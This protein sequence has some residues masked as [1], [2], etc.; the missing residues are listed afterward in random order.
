[1]VCGDCIRF[2]RE[3]SEAI[4][5]ASLRR[6]EFP[7]HVPPREAL[8]I[9]LK[10]ARAK[11]YQLMRVPMRP[12]LTGNNIGV[13]RS[14]FLRING[15][16]ERYVGWGLEDRD[17]QYRLERVGVRAWSILA[18]TR[19]IHLWHEPHPTFA[20]NGSG[21]PNLSYFSN[22]SRR[23]A[24]CAFGLVKSATVGSSEPAR[25]APPPFPQAI[26]T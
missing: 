4:D 13:W 8:R 15:F 7:W 2:G 6:G 26:A 12:R 17:L 5:E 22:V 19:P 24:F 11:W 23:P 9:S 16:D 10:A 20:R 14:D 1:M 21:T 25:C 3:A 18:R